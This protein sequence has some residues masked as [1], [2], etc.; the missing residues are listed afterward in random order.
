MLEKMQGVLDIGNENG[1]T[2]S[3]FLNEVK[4]K[5]PGCKFGDFQ[6]DD[7]FLKKYTGSQLFLH[8]H[9]LIYPVLSYPPQEIL[10]KSK[11]PNVG[12]NQKPKLIG[13]NPH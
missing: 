8:G 3:F 2:N 4:V 13:L 1:G 7:K 11:W 6:V 5:G 10:A 9:W 12:N